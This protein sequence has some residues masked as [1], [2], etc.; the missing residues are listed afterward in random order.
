MRV[1]TTRG[2]KEWIPRYVFSIDKDNCI[3]C[4]R[5]YKVCGRDVLSLVEQDEDNDEDIK[6]YMD[7]SNPDNCIGCEA[8]SRVCPKKCFTHMEVQ[9]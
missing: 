8:C 6:P 5:C 3:G 2:G 4:G 9:A 1:F 7:I